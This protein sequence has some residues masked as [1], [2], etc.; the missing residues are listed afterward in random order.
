MKERIETFTVLI[1]KIGRNIRKIKNQEMSE[2]SLRGPHVF[3]IYY[4]YTLGSLT[5]T[6]L[7]ERCEEDKATISRSIDYLVERGFVER[8]DKNAKRYNA[9]LSLTENGFIAG[10]KICDKVDRVLYEAGAGLNEEERVSFYQS[11]AI[12]SDNLERLAN[13]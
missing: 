2:Y 5:V 10:E 7:A 13:K 9:H 12:I 6:E 3:C 4:L 11:L 8:P 1:A